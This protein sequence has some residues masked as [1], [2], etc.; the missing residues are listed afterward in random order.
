MKNGLVVIDMLN[1]FQDGVLAN[2]AAEPIVEPFKKL[3]EAARVNDD[4][5]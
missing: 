2:S 1:D 4:W 5:L 3:I